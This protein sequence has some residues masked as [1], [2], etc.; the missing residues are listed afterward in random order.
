[1]VYLPPDL[2]AQVRPRSRRCAA[3]SDRW[4]ASPPSCSR[5][6]RFL[7]KARGGVTSARRG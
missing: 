5:T 3:S 6:S 4:T 1:V 7:C 2:K